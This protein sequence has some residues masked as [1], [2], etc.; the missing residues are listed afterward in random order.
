[1][2]DWVYDPDTGLIS[3]N[4]V[5]KGCLEASGYVKLYYKGKV[6]RA[7]RLAY[8]LQGLEIP[9]QV[10]HKNGVRHDNRW[11]NLR[12]ASNMQ[13]QYNRKPTSKQGHLKG[14]QFNKRA[15]VWY[16]Q[17]RVDGKRYHLGTFATEEA[18]HSAYVEASRKLHGEFSLWTS[19]GSEQP[20]P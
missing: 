11:C 14:A 18:A 5:V 6:W 15:K 3:C 2:A 20:K 19:R 13:N 4:G 10:D 9:K 16:S 12:A 7:H 8:E 1:M 17:I